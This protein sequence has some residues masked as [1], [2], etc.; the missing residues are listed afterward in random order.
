MKL[1]S[2]FSLLINTV[3]VL[4]IN[5][6]THFLENLSL[7]SGHAVEQ[8]Q[9][10][11]ERINKA[12]RVSHTDTKTT[13]ALAPQVA[14]WVTEACSDTTTLKTYALQEMFYEQKALTRQLFRLY[15]HELSWCEPD[16]IEELQKNIFQL[17]E[18]IEQ[19]FSDESAVTAYDALADYKDEYDGKLM[20]K[21]G[22]YALRAPE[23]YQRMQLAIA[24]SNVATSGMSYV[25]GS[26][27]LGLGTL[28]AAGIAGLGGYFG[29]AAALP[30]AGYYGY[31]AAEY[32]APEFMAPI[33]EKMSGGVSYLTPS[34]MPTID[35]SSVL[36]AIP[37]ASFVGSYMP[38]FVKTTVIGGTSVALHTAK[39]ALYTA[40]MNK[41]RSTYHKYIAG[42][43]EDYE[44]KAATFEMHK[45]SLSNL[46]K[47][48]NKTVALIA[49]LYVKIAKRY[50]DSHAAFAQKMTALARELSAP[51]DYSLTKESQ[52][53]FYQRLSTIGLIDLAVDFARSRKAKVI[54]ATNSTQAEQEAFLSALL[55]DSEDTSISIIAGTVEISTPADSMKL[56]ILAQ[57]FIAQILGVKKIGGPLDDNDEIIALNFNTINI[58]KK[59]EVDDEDNADES[60]TTDEE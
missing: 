21:C 17:N 33:S 54:S 22:F 44:S 50:K 29:A 26:S 3:F 49:K 20:A 14:E 7:A 31:K 12:R 57:I 36:K 40:L 55:K 48:T 19:Q 25:V 60:Q 46:I 4:G 38:S 45:K 10:L 39:M 18:M 11:F 51:Q 15:L 32:F 35:A 59:L 9:A 34:W 47:Q 43:S 56:D 1:L 2:L 41:I 42:V 37:G 53:R 27:T 58:I 24:L 28:G 23:L 16:F 8:Q 52:D 13:L 30:F 6:Q 5:A